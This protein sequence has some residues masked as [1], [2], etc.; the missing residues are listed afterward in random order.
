MKLRNYRKKVWYKNWVTS[1]FHIISAFITLH[2]TN[3]ATNKYFLNY[4][5]KHI[6]LSATISKLIL[7][8]IMV[9]CRPFNRSTPLYNMYKTFVILIITT[10][11]LSEFGYVKTNFHDIEKVVKSCCMFLGYM[12]VNIRMYCFGKNFRLIEE[13]N[14]DLSETTIF[15]P[16]NYK[17][18]KIIK[19]GLFLSNLILKL[20]L[21]LING[22]FI[23]VE[24]FAFTVKQQP[25]G[26]WTP[27][28]SEKFFNITYFCQFIYGLNQVYSCVCID[29]LFAIFT[30]QIGTQCDV[31]N[32]R[33]RDLDSDLR[34]TRINLIFCIEHHQKIINW[35]KKIGQAYGE[36]I[37]YQFAISVLIICLSMFSLI[38]V[39]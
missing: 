35:T 10:F 15:Q 37:F 7:M 38:L 8:G 29:S 14:K 23:L 24:S 27:Y 2:K 11:L 16:K 30:I 39:K 4:K 33:I 34:E 21:I 9:G 32:N 6:D 18:T 25:F 13:I 1:I 19:E 17:E 12:G 31:L 20:F 22:T 3:C 26:L 28:N 5:M 36:L